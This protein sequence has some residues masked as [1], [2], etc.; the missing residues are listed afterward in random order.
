MKQEKELNRSEE[1]NLNKNLKNVQRHQKKN[2]LSEMNTEEL[3]AAKTE[4]NIKIEDIQKTAAKTEKE[5]V[6][7]L[8]SEKSIAGVSNEKEMTPSRHKEQ[9]DKKLVLP[10][11]TLPKREKKIKNTEN[12][13][14]ETAE[15]QPDKPVEETADAQANKPEQPKAKKMPARK[16]EK[17]PRPKS[18]VF[19]TVLAV[20]SCIVLFI[21]VI[22]VIFAFVFAAK[23]CEDKPELEIADLVSPDSTTVYDSDGVKI[24]ELGMYL[25]ENITYEEM[26]NELIDAFL[27]IEDS[28]FFEHP[29]FDIPRF[30]KAIMENVRTRDFSQGGSTITMQLIKNSYFSI[31]D[32]ENSTIAARNGMSGVKRKMQEIV[33]ALELENVKKVSKQEIIA[34][35]INKVNYG[36]NIRGVEKA[37]EYYFGKETKNLN[38]SECA[39]LA[40]LINSPNSY[41]PYND[42]SKYDNYYL[43]PDTEYLQDGTAR[44]NEV[45]DLMVMHGYISEA[46]A[47]LAK[48]VRIEDQLSGVD[49]SFA[50]YNEKY[51]SYIDAV[52][53][54]VIEVT[55]ES[56]Y[57]VGMEIYTNMNAYMQEYVYDM[58]NGAEYVGLT[59]PNDLCQSAIVVLDNQNGAIEALGIKTKALS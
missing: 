10:R 59:F 49:I 45:L 3:S 8:I 18:R 6:A 50:E 7:P 29:G 24:M 33:L 11:I 36:N 16:K 44:R 40:G 25:R 35:Y 56:P 55:G 4:E 20:L 13:V 57:A 48:S 19:T 28:R 37:A 53:D 32:D 54:E 15:T 51:Q 41:N 9:K 17:T 34:M 14:E 2:P 30:T 43:D 22:G 21:G 58:Q 5:P 12:T 42:L 26:P 31:D 1:R 52:I 23:L 47:D 39:F 46:E 27:A 38:L